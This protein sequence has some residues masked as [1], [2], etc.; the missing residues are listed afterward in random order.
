[1]LK[2][3]LILLLSHFTVTTPATFTYGFVSGQ[4]NPGVVE[5]SNNYV[6]HFKV[7]IPIAGACRLEIIFPASMPVTTEVTPAVTGTGVMTAAT[8]QAVDT[9]NRKVL[10]NGCT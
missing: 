5:E 9:A 8:S 3:E 1:M 2:E 10:V 4:D 7:P 6:F